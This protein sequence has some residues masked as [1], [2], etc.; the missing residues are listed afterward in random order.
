MTILFRN[1]LFLSVIFGHLT[2]DIFNNMGPVIVTFYSISMGLNAF[3]IG[4]TLGLYQFVGSITQPLFGWLA[5]KAGTRWLGPGSVAWSIFFLVL[6][7]IFANTTQNFLLFMIPYSLASIGSGAFHPQ[8]A[9][10]ASTVDT[11]RAATATG[12]FFLFGQTGLALGPLLGGFLL[13]RLEAVGIYGAAILSIPVLIFMVYG[14]QEANLQSSA[15]SDDVEQE[16]IGDK[17]VRWGAIGLLALIIGFRSWVT[18][19]TV[20]FLP[21]LFQTMGWAPTSY[22]AIAG[23][24]WIGSATAGVLGGYVADRL[25]R[26]QVITVTLIIGSIFVYF[27]PLNSGWLAFPIAICV[28]IFLGAPHSILVVIGQ[29]LLPGRRAFASGVTLGYLFGMGAIAAWCI[30]ILTDIW[31]LNVVIQAG[32]LAGFIAA[33]LA[34][35]LP[36]TRDQNRSPVAASTS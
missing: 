12:L 18:L 22:G 27:L 4:L 13:D 34:I 10:H 35:F 3:Q 7:V 8:G 33:V 32:S 28:G 25:G 26:R 11:E 2:L 36:S 23:A 5:D 16:T 21:K 20:L 1:K 15:D 24:F 29:D 9:M 6:S 31:T 19:G 14:M 17:S 30:G